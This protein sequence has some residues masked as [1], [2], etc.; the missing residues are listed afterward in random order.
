MDTFKANVAESA[1]KYAVAMM[2]ARDRYKANKTHYYDMP[3]LEKGEKGFLL[4]EKKN[5][6]FEILSKQRVNYSAI[7]G[8]EKELISILSQ[9]DK[10][11]DTDKKRIQLGRPSESNIEQVTNGSYNLLSIV[12]NMIKRIKIL[13]NK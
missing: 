2:N 12:F 13:T 3:L 10:D 7:L 1:C 9:I 4:S 6:E 8:I 5:L 11:F